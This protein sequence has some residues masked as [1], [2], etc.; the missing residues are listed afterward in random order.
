MGC[1]ASRERC[2]GLDSVMEAGELPR[3]SRV[4]RV[5]LA[6][7]WAEGE[8]VRRTKDKVHVLIRQNGATRAVAVPLGCAAAAGRPQRASIGSR[9]TFSS[10]HCSDTPFTLSVSR[11]SSEEGDDDD[12]DDDGASDYTDSLGDPLEMMNITGVQGR[13]FFRLSTSNALW[14]S[15]GVILEGDEVIPGIYITPPPQ[16]V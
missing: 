14:G 10:I 12:D 2:D 6:D 3:D 7:G 1:G 13:S 11:D 4:V 5:K 8:V 15:S 9:G 16:H